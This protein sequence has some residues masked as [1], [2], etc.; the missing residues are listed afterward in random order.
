[1]KNEKW[2]ESEKEYEL[3]GDEWVA[4]RKKT[5][6]LLGIS[7]K[8]KDIWDIIFK[9]F[10][11]TA[12]FSPLFIL[13]YQ[14]NRENINKKKAN[15]S[16]LYSELL[17]DIKLF[18]LRDS[19]QYDAFDK[20]FKIYPAKFALYG[21]PDIS[22]MYDSLMINVELACD[23]K[24]IKK[25]Y[26]GIIDI[27]V[28]FHKYSDWSYED[29]SFFILHKTFIRDSSLILSAIDKLD[30]YAMD[31]LYCPSKVLKLK[32]LT[33]QNWDKPFIKHFLNADSN[34][35]SMRLYCE[36]LWDSLNAPNQ[37]ADHEIMLSYPKIKDIILLSDSADKSLVYA[38]SLL[39]I[40]KRQ[41]QDL[42]IQELK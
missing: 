24:L 35:N 20:F 3:D 19:S 40:R 15:L 4:K 28:N 38:D 23:I 33:S 18:D 21:N 1:V 11:A 29:S 34:I 31:A 12:I 8:T 2:I 41:F 37:K 7:Q 39:S 16:Q 9:F 10:A 42:I 14:N 22:N 27:Q 30:F 6:R 17:P 5:I 25:S 26:D 32:D 13:L 36:Q